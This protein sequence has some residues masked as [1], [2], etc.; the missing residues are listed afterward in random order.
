M[1]GWMKVLLGV[2][3]SLGICGGVAAFVYDLHPMR[4]YYD[5]SNERCD[6]ERGPAIDCYDDYR[7]VMD[8]ADGQDRWVALAA[9]VGAVALFWLLANLFYFRPRR[10]RAEQIPPM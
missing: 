10:R 5:S 8:A 1:A 9:G 3:L 4:P 7:R 2:V 6:Q